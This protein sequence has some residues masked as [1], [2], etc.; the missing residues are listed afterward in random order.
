MAETYA[1]AKAPGR[2]VDDAKA[3]APRASNAKSAR[4]RV[5]N[6]LTLC[7]EVKRVADALAESAYKEDRAV[8]AYLQSKLDE[9]ERDTY[10]NITNLADGCGPLTDTERM[11]MRLRYFK[12]L[13]VKDISR[14]T[15]LAYQYVQ[16]V[17]SKVSKKYV[18]GQEEFW[19]AGG[20]L[21]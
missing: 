13:P 18:I 19:T 7:P 11:L 2:R 21:E 4:M 9:M 1:K 8:A 5:G 6:Y 10:D 3:K 17:C 15:G 14:R 16:N 12:G 20:G